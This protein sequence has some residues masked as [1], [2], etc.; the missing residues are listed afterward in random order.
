MLGGSFTITAAQ[1][2]FNNK[3]ISKL[4]ARAPGIDPATVLATGASQIRTAFT[5]AQVPL[6][7]EAYMTGLKVVFAIAIATFGMAFLFGC[8]AGMK[9]LHVEDLK[10]VGGAA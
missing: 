3:M 2:A 10:N 9:K 7:V 6:V 8:G 5:A 1:S 4:A